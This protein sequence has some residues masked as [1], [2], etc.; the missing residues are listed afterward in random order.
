MS[1]DSPFADRL[2]TNYI[3][4][5]EE[6][7]G[8]RN[9][10]EQHCATVRELDSKL[11]A[12]NK[13]IADP[14][15]HRRET[16]DHH[17]FTYAHQALL[18]CVLRLSPDILSEIFMDLAPDSGQWNIQPR[19]LPHPI[20]WISHVVPGRLGAQAIHMFRDQYHILPSTLY[21][22]VQPAS[23]L[24]TS[25]TSE[26]ARV[27]P[28]WTTPSGDNRAIRTKPKRLSSS[29]DRQHIRRLL[30]SVVLSRPQSQPETLLD[31]IENN[32]KLD[33]H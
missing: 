23:P 8:I 27:G 4:S 19:T 14:E 3:P 24:L 32:G 33:T 20:I 30:D 2:R 15:A 21:R 16:I 12:I 29:L 7:P 10:I 13:T 25:L 28:L 11:A 22:G 9:I 17:T 5:P 1:F 26:R 31:T 6:E 18:S